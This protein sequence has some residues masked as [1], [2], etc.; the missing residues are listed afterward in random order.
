MVR[1]H[2]HAVGERR[3]HV[4][5]NNEFR[6]VRDGEA[7]V[8]ARDDPVN[9]IREGKRHFFFRLQKAHRRKRGEI[10]AVANLRARRNR[11]VAHRDER[12][13][14]RTHLDD[15]VFRHRPKG[16]RADVPFL[17]Q[18]PTDLRAFNFV[19]RLLE[20][21]EFRDVLAAATRGIAVAG[22]VVAELRGRDAARR[23]DLE[24]RELVGRHGARRV[25]HKRAIHEDR[26]RADALGRVAGEELTVLA[27]M[28]VVGGR[29][30][31]EKRIRAFL[32]AGDHENRAEIARPLE[33]EVAV[34]RR[35]AERHEAAS[36]V[37]NKKLRPARRLGG[38]RVDAR[39]LA[40]LVRARP[41]GDFARLVRRDRRRIARVEPEVGVLAKVVLVPLPDADVIDEHPHGQG[42]RVGDLPHPGA[43]QLLREDE[44]EVRVE[45]PLQIPR[46]V[47]RVGVRRHAIDRP[48]DRVRR[49]LKAVDVELAVGDGGGRP[50]RRVA[51]VVAEVRRLVDF[52]V[53]IEPLGDVDLAAI[54][55]A[56]VNGI[57]RHHPHRRPRAALVLELG[58]DLDLS[59]LEA[60]LAVRLDLPA[61]ELARVAVGEVVENARQHEA[62]VRDGDQVLTVRS[63]LPPVRGAT[64]HDGDFFPLARVERVAA[65]LLVEDQLPVALRV[66]ETIARCLQPHG[67]DR[68]AAHARETRADERFFKIAV[69]RIV[70]VGDED[71]LAVLD[72]AQLARAVLDDKRDAP[73]AVHREGNAAPDVAVA[74]HGRPR[75]GMRVGGGVA[76]REEE[77]AR[78]LAVDGKGD[79]R[80][81]AHEAD[82]L[83]I[84]FP[85]RRRGIVWQREDDLKRPVLA[86]DI[87]LLR[88]G[89][90]PTARLAPRAVE[91][92]GGI[93]NRVKILKVAALDDGGFAL[94]NR[95]PAAL[96]K[97]H[98]RANR[99]RDGLKERVPN[100]A[101]FD[102]EFAADLDGG[103][104]NRRRAARLA[105]KAA[106][107]L[108]AL[109]LAALAQRDIDVLDEGGVRRH[110]GEDAHG[111]LAGEGVQ[112]P[113]RV[114]S[115][116]L[117]VPAGGDREDAGVHLDLEVAHRAAQCAD[118]PRRLFRDDPRVVVENERVAVA[119]QH[120]RPLVDDEGVVLE[121]D[122]IREFR[123]NSRVVGEPK[124]V[125][126]FFKLIP[127]FTIL[128]HD[129]G[130][131]PGVGHRPNRL[132]LVAAKG[133]PPLPRGV[134]V[135]PPTH[136]A[137][138]VLAPR[139]QALR[140]KGTH[141]LER[142]IRVV[143][144]RPPNIHVEAA[145]GIVRLRF[146]LGGAPVPTHVAV[147]RLIR[148]LTHD[149]APLGEEAVR[150]D[151][152]RA[153][154]D[155]RRGVEPATAVGL[156][157]HVVADV[158]GAVIGRA[159]R[160]PGARPIIAAR[161]E[162]K[163]IALLE[164]V[165]GKFAEHLAD[166]LPFAVVCR[167]LNPLVV[168]VQAVALLLANE[169]DNRLRELPPRH[170]VRARDLETLAADPVR[171]DAVPRND[172]DADHAVGVVSVA[173]PAETRRR[174]GVVVGLVPP[175]D[176][177]LAVG[178]AVARRVDGQNIRQRLEPLLGVRGENV[179]VARAVV[180]EAVLSEERAD[181][182]A[183]G[184]GAVRRTRLLVVESEIA[185]R[186]L[187][188]VAREGDEQLR[189]RRKPLV[190]VRRHPHVIALVRRAALRG[191]GERVG[192]V[193]RRERDLDAVAGLAP[194]RAEAG[195]EKI[196]GVALEERERQDARA[197]VVF[198]PPHADVGD[199]VGRRVREVEAHREVGDRPRRAVEEFEADQRLLVETQRQARVGADDRGLADAKDVPLLHQVVAD[200]LSLRHRQRVREEKD[201]RDVLAAAT[202]VRVRVAFSVV[203]KLRGGEG[204]VVV[205]LGVKEREAL[206]H[207][208]GC[209]R[210]DGHAVHVNGAVGAGDAVFPMQDFARRAAMEMV[211]VRVA[212]QERIAALFDLG[213]HEDLLDVLGAREGEVA[214]GTRRAE[215]DE[216]R[217]SLLETQPG[218]GGRPA[219]VRAGERV[220]RRGD[221]A[222]DAAP[223]GD[224][225]IRERHRVCLRGVEPE[226]GVV[227]HLWRGDGAECRDCHQPGD[228]KE[229]T[230]PPFRSHRHFSSI[231][232]FVKL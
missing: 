51:I 88:E 43:L 35:R 92:I 214:A 9:Q 8:R 162:G 69:A 65:K 55:P 144:V 148:R 81:R 90:V 103:I 232:S 172:R 82:Q 32:Q 84:G 62:S 121:G 201:F 93:G 194:R 200:V 199:L 57:L 138:Q 231:S 134:G 104:A 167:I 202:R 190:D 179:P 158:E 89:R 136:H 227:A 211:C 3:L 174:R 96:D 16:L 106:D 182:V 42:G 27:A 209:G 105:D 165:F 230:S 54:R 207:R 37:V 159:V 175:G 73:L 157:H 14:R 48:R 184:K 125:V 156:H 52:R 111:V 12:W 108:N 41:S 164:E 13:Q 177:E 149:D 219:R 119:V 77:L 151:G 161:R 118:K 75:D 145:E 17:H 71:R 150:A 36:L 87:D 132:R 137:A 24:Q 2:P 23:V 226:V 223:F 210:G 218:A 64:R 216:G 83:R 60:E 169:I 198:L 133:V 203:A 34:R 152:E 66:G 117:V 39:R 53:G 181:L 59:I 205:G 221:A 4:L 31:Q 183:E 1:P 50:A 114:G 171:R 173:Q 70:L 141:A 18:R 61:E 153:A 19:K 208:G 11:V 228:P 79:G 120:A 220:G 130:R 67:E 68:P 58:A 25:A 26:A 166:V 196:D 224:F 146:D 215:R 21:D 113:P 195:G 78:A 76:A 168:D 140:L 135:I 110:G 147:E 101:H 197:R 102:V 116:N 49:P 95:D 160:H 189:V 129:F 5:E 122:V 94:F 124:P 112:E 45:R 206:R 212:D 38:E 180:D 155:A 6:R 85:Q 213:D 10:L 186:Q 126:L 20:E 98:E 128:L 163:D 191:E 29:V 185:R 99:R 56:A 80:R 100:V 33:G 91:F 46:P 225:A 204:F 170:R 63:V 15:A 22:A 97:P 123:V 107:A 187:N 44:V 229:K 192:D 47:V 154:V 176:V 143:F 115:V 188:A 217:G 178:I 109:H 131:R 7:R 40:R 86:S 72:D 222:V 28:E 139:P 74:A 30:A 193:R 127:R 142:P